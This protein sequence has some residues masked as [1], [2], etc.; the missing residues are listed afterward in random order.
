VGA[1]ACQVHTQIAVQ[2][3]PNGR[4]V[5]DVTVTL[6]KAAVA[7]LGGEAAL[8]AQLQHADLETAGWTVTGPAPGPGSTTVLRASHPFADLAEA[9]QLVEEVAGNGPAGSRPFALSVSKHHGFW[10]TDTVLSGKVDLTCGLDC[11]GD[12]GLSKA[13]GSPIGVDPAPLI[14]AAGQQPNRVFSF[15]LSADLP[16]TLRSTNAAARQG[17][18]LEWNPQLG[19]AIE[20][21]A[22]TRTWNHGRIVAAV[23]VAGGLVLLLL[24]L[25]AFWW[26]RRRRRRRRRQALEANRDPETVAPHS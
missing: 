9:S 11:F 23:S 5:V 17:T 15:S 1:A 25:T 2:A 12:P 24:G 16:G 14:A 6:D 7:A 3:A 10:Y 8:A 13:L 19:H 26:V 22:V 18:T 20:L 21:A 4:G